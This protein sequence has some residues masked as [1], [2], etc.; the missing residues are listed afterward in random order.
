MDKMNFVKSSRD[1]M[2]KN[3][4]KFRDDNEN[5]IKATFKSLDKNIRNELKNSRKEYRAEAKN[6]IDQLKDKSVSFEQKIQ[7]KKDLDSLR[8]TKYADLKSKLQSNS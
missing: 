6:I 4:A 2:K 8:A 7:L 3:I 1:E 5:T